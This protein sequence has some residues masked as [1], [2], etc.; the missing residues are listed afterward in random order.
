MNSGASGMCLSHTCVP[1]AML[2]PLILSEDE[3]HLE[4]DIV[5]RRLEDRE[6]APPPFGD[7]ILLFLMK[8]LRHIQALGQRRAFDLDPVRASSRYLCMTPCVRLPAMA[9][10]QRLKPAR[11]NRKCMTAR[12][13]IR[14]R[15]ALISAG[16]CAALRTKALP[17]HA[18]A[19][20]R[21][22]VRPTPGSAR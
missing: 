12:R 4:V 3:R 20:N 17:A 18:P 15:G 19:E 11:S 7:L 21:R 22:A 14:C 16:S 5:F 9:G 2:P 10:Y 6:F 1:T 13:L 8:L